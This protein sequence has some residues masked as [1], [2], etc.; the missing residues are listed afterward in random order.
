[1]SGAGGHARLFAGVEGTNAGGGAGATGEVQFGT[2]AATIWG[3]WRRGA[4]LINTTTPSG[5]ELL[6]VNGA[7]R[8]E[9]NLTVTGS[10]AAAPLFA[11]DDASTATALTVLTL[12]RTTSGAALANIG[13]T[14][15]FESE[16]GA[17]N[18]ESVAS[19]SGSLSTVTD[20][21][22][23]GVLAFQTRTGGGA[24]TSRWLMNA[25][26]NLVAATDNT[27]DIGLVGALRPRN[28][29]LA[30]SATIGGAFDH[31]GS[32]LGVFGVAPT[33][34]KTAG[35]NLTNNV[36]VGG[37]TDQIDDFLATVAI[38]AVNAASQP[39]VNARLTSIR[40]DIYQLARALKQDHD[41]LRAYGF[42]T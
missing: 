18:V 13:A 4:L 29:V 33:T 11:V 30:G 9:G 1:M 26:G 24:L 42:L 40:N 27:Y 12:R 28:L 10:T 34:Q 39:D 37:T 16:D 3:R 38:D 31:D 7:A 21:A 19:I 23:A 25:A 35:G 22:E 17:G 15:L 6:R 8:V 5:S 14:L 41:A 20:A 36:T 32:S 2:N